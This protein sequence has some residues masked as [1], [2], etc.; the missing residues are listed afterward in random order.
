MSTH[1]TFTVVTNLLG[2][3]FY[4][5]KVSLTLVLF[6]HIAVS[7]LNAVN[8]YYAITTNNPTKKIIFFFIDF[9]QLVV[10]LMIKSFVMIRAILLR[11]SDGMY[12]ERANQV[13]E[14]AIHRRCKIKFLVSVAVFTILC[15][16]KTTTSFALNYVVYNLA[17]YFPT[18]LNASSDLMFVYYIN[19]LTEHLKYIRFA[20][21]NVAEEILTNIDMQRLIQKRYSANLVLTISTYFLLIIFA[22]YW[23][24]VRIVFGFFN[25]LDGKYRA[26]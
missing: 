15:S 6:L 18:I 7:V 17:Q 26:L 4:E 22:L 2:L 20:K 13:F 1:K 11:N 10:P 25:T 21:C 9:V 12:S 16:M 14:A 3:N 24:F 8:I 19:C 5:Q 23:I